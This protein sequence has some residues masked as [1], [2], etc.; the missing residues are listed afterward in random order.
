MVASGRDRPTGI[1]PHSWALKWGIVPEL[2]VVVC[3]ALCRAPSKAR[4]G[5]LCAGAQ[6]PPSGRQTSHLEPTWAVPLAAI[7]FYC[8]CPGAA[9]GWGR[10][11]EMNLKIETIISPARVCSR[12][13]QL[14]QQAHTPD[15]DS[16]QERGSGEWLLGFNTALA[17]VAACTSVHS[18]S[19]HVASHPV[20]CYENVVIPAYALRRGPAPYLRTPREALGRCLSNAGPW[21]SGVESHT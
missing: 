12:R 17:H 7:G 5:S 9:L 19:K 11:M 13:H 1:L 4:V 18:C 14:L 6:G 21:K 2:C 10:R 15:W 16:F 3:M 8:W 20:P